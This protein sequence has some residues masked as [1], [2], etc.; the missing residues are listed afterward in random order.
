M[1]TVYKIKEKKTL[2]EKKEVAKKKTEEKVE[3]KKDDK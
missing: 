2:T 1:S 3:P